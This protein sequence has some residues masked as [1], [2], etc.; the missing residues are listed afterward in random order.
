MIDTSLLLVKFLKLGV[1]KDEENIFE[2]LQGQFKNIEK[3]KEMKRFRNVLVHQYEGIDNE[4]VY[5]NATYNLK[6]FK[7]FIDEVKSILKEKS[8]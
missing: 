4:I 2:K 8:D 3:Y 6:D 7:K 1:P 5:H